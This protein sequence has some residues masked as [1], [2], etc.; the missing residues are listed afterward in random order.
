MPR[1]AP[2]PGA[3]SQQR[4]RLGLVCAPTLA[5]AAQRSRGSRRGGLTRASIRT[6]ARASC[7][8][9][10]SS[11]ISNPSP[12]ANQKAVGTTFAVEAARDV[13]DQINRARAQKPQHVR[14]AA[15]F[16]FVDG[17]TRN[18]FRMQRFG[19][20]WRR[21][22]QKPQLRQLARFFDEQD[23]CRPSSPATKHATRRPTKARR[24]QRF[25]QRFFDGIAETTDFPV[26]AISTP[27]S[28]SAPDSLRNEN[29]GALT[30]TKSRS[31]GSRSGRRST[32]FPTSPASPSQ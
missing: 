6:T 30:T 18:P 21:V 3:A 15:T 14:I 25:G 2:K 24:E 28:G 32:F 23:I 10:V 7:K 8:V 27:S 19:R 16:A 12:R 9:G 31:S 13:D 4:G 29:I 20:P 5:T 1:H 11:G 26:A 22:Q 17:M